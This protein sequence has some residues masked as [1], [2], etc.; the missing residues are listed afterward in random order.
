MNI[1]LI[2]AKS[3]INMYLRRTQTLLEASFDLQEN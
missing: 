1:Y 3:N 2:I